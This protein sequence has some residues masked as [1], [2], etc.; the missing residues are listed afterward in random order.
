MRAAA[1]STG[2][3]DR[4]QAS[5]RVGAG[6]GKVQIFDAAMT[7]GRAKIGQLHQVVA[8]AM[9]GAFDQIVAFLPGERGKAGL[10]FDV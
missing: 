2:D 10:E 9:R 8:E 5:A 3:H 7:V 6:T 4:R 1:R